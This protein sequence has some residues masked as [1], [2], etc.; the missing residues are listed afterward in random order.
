VSVQVE[1]DMNSKK[2][3]VTR[4]V[5]GGLE[6][7]M[8]QIPAVISCDLRLNQPRFAKLQDIMKAKKK[9]IDKK[10][11]EQLGVE[12]TPRLKTISVEEPPQKKAGAKVSSVQE[13]VEKLKKDGFI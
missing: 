3:T 10:T 9:T 8:L 7:L 5:D 11:P 13:L 12:I 6:K 1:V 2:L 4:E